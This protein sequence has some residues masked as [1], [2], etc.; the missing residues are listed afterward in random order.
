MPVSKILAKNIM[1]L[2]HFFLDSLIG[3]EV[4]LEP[5]MEH[6]YQSL[7]HAANDER[8][9]RYMPMKAHDNFFDDWFND[10]LMKH[11]KGTQITY[12]IRRTTDQ[13]IVG[14]RA[15]Y[16]IDTCHKRLEVGYGWFT[17]TVWG[18]RLNHESLWLLFRQAFEQWRFNRI[19]IAADPKNKRSYYTLKK[20]GAKEEGF[21]RQHM[22]HH[23]GL[24]TDTVLFSILASE[25]PVLKE[26][27]W[28]RLNRVA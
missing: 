10:S 19:Q 28:R 6:H 2:D 1:T 23:N 18:T 27:L 15:Y 22:I 4:Q 13:R 21:L 25:W 20:L 3:K 26:T 5:L 16:D 14:S 7:R 24:I 9:W 12:A 8:I 17:P 11:A